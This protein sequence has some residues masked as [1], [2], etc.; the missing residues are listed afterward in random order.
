MRRDEQSLGLVFAGLCALNGSLVPGF[1]KL[2]TNSGDPIFV[3]A[4]TTVFAGIAATLVLAIRGELREVFARRNLPR[5][6]T[7]GFLGTAAAF[8]LFYAGAKRSTAIEAVICM[9][10][11]P[12]YALLAAWIFLGHRPTRRRLLAAVVLLGGIVLAIGPTGFKGSTGVWFLLATPLCWQASHLV[13]LRGLVGVVP[14]VL[15]AARYLYGGLLLVLFWMLSGA[16]TDLPAGRDPAAL[17]ALLAVQGVLLAYVGTLLWYQAI[18]R[19]DLGRATA[20][21]VPSTPLLS[22]VASFLLLGET[23]SAA[24]WAGLLLTAGGVLAFVTA[25]HQA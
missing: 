4:A 14:Q 12:A 19:L 6:A 16:H 11:E 17:L 2:T 23:P 21:V 9:Q 20:I 8:G 22:L 13:V 3:A 1:A 5:L 15:T 25:P 24:Q 18:R 7:I 10:I